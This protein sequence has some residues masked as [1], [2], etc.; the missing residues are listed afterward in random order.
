MVGAMRVMVDKHTHNVEHRMWS[1]LLEGG[2]NSATAV[3]TSATLD[4]VGIYT[5]HRTL[6]RVS[7][8][9]GCF[10]CA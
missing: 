10:F 8:L 6:P 7:C 3:G 2:L 5:A 4:V 1:T 9:I